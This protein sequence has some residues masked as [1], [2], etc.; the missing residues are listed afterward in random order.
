MLRFPHFSVQIYVF[1]LWC[2][3]QSVNVI[4]K[5]QGKHCMSGLSPLTSNIIG[6][7][8]ILYCVTTGDIDQTL[9]PLPNR[10]VDT[11]MGLERVTSILQGTMSNY[12]T[13]LFVPLFNKIYKVHY[14][15]SNC[16]GG[17]YWEIKTPRP[18]ARGGLTWPR[19]K[20]EVRSDHREHWVEGLFSQ[21]WPP[22]QL[23]TVLLCR[24]T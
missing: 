18:S 20:A 13:D 9:F 2:H 11:G 21:Y 22:R 16:L 5:T 12:D 19:P 8:S 6:K 1:F 24:E 17:Q 7:M 3:S 4:M 23:P 10:H 15:V 14:T